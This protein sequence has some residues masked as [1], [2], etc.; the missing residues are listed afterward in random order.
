LIAEV[1]KKKCGYAVAKQHFF[2][3]FLTAAKGVIADV[4]KCS[5]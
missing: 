5:F 4:W 2:K 1:Q 3:N